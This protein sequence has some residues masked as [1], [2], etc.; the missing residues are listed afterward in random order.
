[1]HSAFILTKSPVG[2]PLPAEL[3]QCVKELTNCKTNAHRPLQSNRKH[4]EKIISFPPRVPL[5]LAVRGGSSAAQRVPT[6]VYVQFVFGVSWVVNQAAGDA[7]E[8]RE[9]VNNQTVHTDGF[10]IFL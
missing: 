3:G 4:L 2:G 6:S 10:P 8:V 5:C 7:I 9:S 1:M